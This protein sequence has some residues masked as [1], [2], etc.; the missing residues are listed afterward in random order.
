MLTTWFQH[1]GFEKVVAEAWAELGVPLQQVMTEFHHLATQWNRL[2]FE[3]IFE[4]KNDAKH[5]LRGS[6]DA[7]NTN[8]LDNWND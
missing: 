3:N 6:S 2:C 4:R 5:G 7:L 8:P 1:T